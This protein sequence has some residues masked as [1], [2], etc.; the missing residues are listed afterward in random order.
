MQD[1]FSRNMGSRKIF[2]GTSSQ[3][4]LMSPVDKCI[5]L[6]LNVIIDFPSRQGFLALFKLVLDG[7]L[8]DVRDE[9]WEMDSPSKFISSTSFC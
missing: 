8:Q 9:H 3:K 2:C 5:D 7:L 4:F 6:N 1:F